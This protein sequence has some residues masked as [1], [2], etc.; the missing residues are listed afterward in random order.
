MKR[1][2]PMV[3]TRRKTKSA[4]GSTLTEVLVASVILLFGIVTVA[5][6][7]PLSINRN[8]LN[9]DDSKA[10]VVAEQVLDQILSQNINAAVTTVVVDGQ[11]FV[12]SIGGPGAGA[13]GS[14]IVPGANGQPALDYSVPA[15]PGYSFVSADPNDPTAPNIE[16]RLGVITTVAGTGPVSK[17]FAVAAWRRDNTQNQIFSPVVFDGFVQR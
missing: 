4:A 10:T 11:A 16:V 17:R 12:I 7:V 15:V 14:P 6:L 8:K 13:T 3:Q 2:F 9:R 1:S 5:R